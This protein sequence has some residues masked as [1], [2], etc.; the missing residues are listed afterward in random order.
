V[1]GVDVKDSHKTHFFFAKTTCKTG[2]KCD[3]ITKVS[4]LLSFSIANFR[5]FRG[6][7]TLS[8][9]ASSRHPDHPEH[10]AI[11]PDDENKALPVAVIYGANGAGKSNFVKAL[12][13]L[14]GLVLAGTEPEWPIARRPFLL[15]N[16]SPAKPTELTIQF[17][18]GGRVYVFGCKVSDKVVNAEWLSLLRDG[19]EIPI[20]ERLTNDKE[21]VTVEAGPV[22][23]DRTWGD[24]VKALALTKVGVLPNQLFLH[25]L[26]KSLREQ[27][28]GPLIAAVLRWFTDRLNIVPASAT[29]SALAQWV[30]KEETFTAFAGDFLRKVATGVDRLRFRSTQIEE[31]ELDPRM[32]QLIRDLPPGNMIATGSDGTEVIVE[33]G[34]GTKVRL[35]T[36]ESEHITSD[37][38]RVSLPFSEESDGTQRLTHLL[39]ALHS[40]CQGQRLFVIDEID[41]SLHPLLAKGFVRAFL[42][43]AA[44]RGSQ[45]I[46]TTHEI[47]FLDLDL[48]RR[49]EIWFADKTRPGGAT[50]LYSLSDYR[51]RKDLRIDKAYLQGRFD[52]VPPIE[53]ELPEWVRQVMEELKPKRAA[54]PEL[55]T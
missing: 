44:G 40:I 37:G 14:E 24:H 55:A 33:K 48:L 46:F 4:M 9:V 11:I 17:V 6:E 25:A 41:R 45:L 51:V 30:A 35:G 10:L 49:D 39:P 8:M 27:D 43:A 53:A 42:E 7:Q 47:A 5:S 32:R 12:A 28:Q 1:T 19:K 54:E 38:T 18:E 13:F 29:F 50:E 26:R 52:A 2:S 36:I 31:G 3:F 23:K 20:Y 22:L 21:E 34:Q 16:E 15:D